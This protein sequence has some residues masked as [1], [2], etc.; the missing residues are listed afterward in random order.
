MLHFRA[1]IFYLLFY[2]WTLVLGL[3]GLPLLLLPG[4]WAQH[5]AR[6][7]LLGGLLLLRFFCGVTHK[8]TGREHIPSTPCIF[9][10]KHQSAWETMAL[11]VLLPQASPSPVFVLKRE[12]LNLPF[13]GWYMQKAGMIA[14]DRSAGVAALKNMMEQAKARLL[15][16]RSLI[17]F[18]EGTR[19][20]VG[21]PPSYKPG[22]A[23]LYKECR[24]PVVPV[25]L[26]SGLFWGKNAFAKNPGTITLAF[27]PPLSP[28]LSKPQ[29]IEA[30]VQT[31][32]PATE[33]LL[34]E[35][36][37]SRPSSS[38]STG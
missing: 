32:E 7:W 26:N 25:A 35:A 8:V 24:V 27:L 22:I 14:I 16:G 18:P 31:I 23:A 37:V 28:D 38:R 9:A 36:Q 30:L 13:V 2:G 12:L 29:V 34:R 21:A 17:I 1:F 11:F 19:A 3:L 15:E 5:L 33:A 20:A 4:I 6:F 10:A